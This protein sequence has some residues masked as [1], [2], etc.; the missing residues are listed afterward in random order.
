VV[1][2][3]NGRFCGYCTSGR[4]PAAKVTS[5]TDSLAAA[6]SSDALAR[7]ANGE[8]AKAKVKASRKTRRRLGWLLSTK[9][10][11]ILRSL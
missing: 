2:R 4:G 10:N 3:V 8:V 7:L 11:F 5:S 6:D 9:L 1:T